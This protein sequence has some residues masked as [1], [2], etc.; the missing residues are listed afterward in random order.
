MDTQVDLSGA[1]KGISPGASGWHDGGGS[2]C[3][4]GFPVCSCQ[5][6]IA[7]SGI[8]DVFLKRSAAASDGPSAAPFGT[9]AFRSSYVVNG[10]VMHKWIGYSGDG[11]GEDWE[12]QEEELVYITK[13]GEAYHRERSCLY[14]NPSIRLAD[15]EEITADYTP[16]SVCVGRGRLENRLIYVTDGGSRYHNTVSCSGLRRTIESVTLMQALEM[17]RHACPRCG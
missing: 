16:C 6:F 10:C 5:S 12:R 2:S 3:T 11:T 7:V 4:A 1:K 14:L 17:G 15:R 9:A 8:L 13:S